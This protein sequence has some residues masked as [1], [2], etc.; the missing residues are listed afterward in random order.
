MRYLLKSLIVVLACGS[1]SASPERVDPVPPERTTPTP[2][3]T[4][5][6]PDDMVLVDFA[7][8]CIDRYEA[9]VENGRAINAEGETPT[10]SITWNDAV[11]AC[12]AVSKRLC[13][14][15][16][17]EAACRGPEERVYPYGDDYVRGRCN[18]G[19]DDLSPDQMQLRPSGS[20][21][22]CK[23]PEGVFDL[24]G[25]LQE[26]RSDL[27]PSRSLRSTGGGSFSVPNDEVVCTR[28]SPTWLAPENA[29]SGVGFRCCADPL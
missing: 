2:E 26:W 18:T 28:R 8:V 19:E 20:R 13:T 4:T 21:P 5:R 14:V 29:L 10:D 11:A 9:R 12:E 6:C 22:E 24:S 1:E 15:A 16:E 3:R 17:W 23:T 27:D 25:N 7:P